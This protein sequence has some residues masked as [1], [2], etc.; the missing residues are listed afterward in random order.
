[1]AKKKPDMSNIF[2]KTDIEPSDIDVSDLDRGR[3]QSTGVG[4]RQGE[5]DALD[6]IGAALGEYMNTKPVARN[7][8]IRLAA[9]GFIENFLAGKITLADLAGN[10]QKEEKPSAKLDL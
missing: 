5:I 6:Q 9:R 4:L 10:F 7:A 2:A 8:L 1:M 3:I